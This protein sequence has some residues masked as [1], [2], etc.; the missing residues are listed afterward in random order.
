MVRPLLSEAVQI[1]V[2]RKKATFVTFAKSADVSTPLTITMT[3][4]S[5]DAS[6]PQ[7]FISLFCGTARNETT[8]K[9]N[10]GQRALVVPGAEL[11]LHFGNPYLS[12]GDSGCA[13]IALSLLPF[14][15]TFRD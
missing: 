11:V 8:M 12:E 6:E 1:K 2:E 7:L 4:A 5:H 15:F 14:R 10:K 13:S 3:L 9:I